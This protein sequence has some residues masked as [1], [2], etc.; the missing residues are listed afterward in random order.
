MQLDVH[1][2]FA[3]S[4]L[5]ANAGDGPIRMASEAPLL[6]YPDKIKLPDQFKITIWS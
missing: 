6:T 3:Y 4:L 1:P 5:D 2:S